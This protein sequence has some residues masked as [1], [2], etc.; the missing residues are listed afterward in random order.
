MIKFADSEMLYL[1]FVLPALVPLFFVYMVL[2]KRAILKLTGNKY[3]TYL[4][5]K[6]SFAKE[7]L[8]FSLFFIAIALMIFSLARPQTGT[9]LEEIKQTGIDL[10]IALDVSKSMLAED[11]RPNRLRKAKNDITSLIRKLQGDR[12]ALIIFAGEAFVQFPLTSDYSAAGL[13]LNAVNENSIPQQG[14]QVAEAINLATKSFSSESN[15]QKAIIIISDGED[16]EGAISEAVKTAAE[17]GIKCFTVGMGTKNGGNIPEAGPAGIQ[18]GFKRDGAGD[19]VTTKLD[20]DIL[21][22]IASEGNGKYFAAASGTDYLNEIYD[23]LSGLEKS[24][25]GTMKITEYDD[26]FYFFL[27]PA[28]L[29]L[30]IELIISDRKVPVI[31]RLLGAKE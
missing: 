21:K 8:K 30:F 31:Q 17:Q 12:L 29:F 7:W 13:F 19:I 26:I 27:I 22:K 18:I 20:E 4:L 1:L 15:T 16:H 25:Y 3:F 5:D 9:R 6:K 11:V 14:T 23:E 10:V 24:E 2:K 28:L